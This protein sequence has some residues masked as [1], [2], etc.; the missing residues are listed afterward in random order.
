MPRPS[1]NSIALAKKVLAKCMAY[2]P[3]FVNPSQSTVLAWAEHIVI[4][5]PSED[6][7]MDA[8]TRFYERNTDG[9]KPLPASITSLASVILLERRE[10]ESDADRLDR[11]ERIDAKVEGRAAQTVRSLVERI[12]RRE[13]ERRH[14]EQFPAF[15]VFPRLVDPKPPRALAYGSDHICDLPRVRKGTVWCCEGCGQWWMERKKKWVM[16][17]A[18]RT[19]Y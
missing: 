1:E 4:R 18:P 12:T 3:Y 15:E 11:E 2:D 17:E 19:T 16:C 14:G 6:D 13:W 8:V 5:N 9:V 10:R 7:M